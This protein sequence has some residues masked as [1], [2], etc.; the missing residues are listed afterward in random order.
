MIVKNTYQKPR[1]DKWQRVLYQHY[2]LNCMEVLSFIGFYK[3]VLFKIHYKRNT[4]I[5]QALSERV[6]KLL[7]ENLY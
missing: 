7:E 4:V 5:T 3:A 6:M 2:K 1:A